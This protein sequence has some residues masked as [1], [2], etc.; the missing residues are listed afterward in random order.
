M[1]F[2]EM[3]F[4][5]F[6][7]STTFCH[8]VTDLPWGS[9]FKMFRNYGLSLLSLALLLLNGLSVFLLPPTGVVVCCNHLFCIAF[10]TSLIC[11]TNPYLLPMLKSRQAWEPLS[12]WECVTRNLSSWTFWLKSTLTHILSTFPCN[13]DE[14]A[15]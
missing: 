5:F 1:L 12:S 14:Q 2:E 8:G 13:L 11:I 6:Y 4:F 9:I 15:L 7:H 10:I 3:H